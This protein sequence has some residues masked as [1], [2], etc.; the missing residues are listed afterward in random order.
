MEYIHTQTEAEENNTVEWCPRCVHPTKNKWTKMIKI[1]LC[2]DSFFFF[3]LLPERGEKPTWC[4]TCSIVT[5]LFR[6]YHDCVSL[7]YRS[8]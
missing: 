8:V 5:L 7:I 2:T 6:S 3:F 1:K 4:I